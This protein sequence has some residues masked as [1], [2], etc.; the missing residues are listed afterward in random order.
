MSKYISKKGKLM[1][2]K[3]EITLNGRTFF[4]GK[5]NPIE[6]MT[7]SRAGIALYQRNENGEFDIDLSTQ[8]NVNAL[9]TFYSMAFEHIFV[10]LSDSL[11]KP[12]KEKNVDVWWPESITQDFETLFA[13]SNWFM[14]EAVFP[15]FTKSNE[16]T[17]NADSL[18]ERQEKH[19]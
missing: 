5:I 6:M 3:K 18:D 14:Q 12:V 7:I 9:N 15:I 2:E 10:K 17:E 8:K 19:S 1:E 13:L 11:V 16:S 4:I